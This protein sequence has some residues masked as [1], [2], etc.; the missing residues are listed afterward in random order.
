MFVVFSQCFVYM[1][2]GC[3]LPVGVSPEA[4]PTQG[5][6]VTPRIS[7]V[8]APIPVAILAKMGAVNIASWR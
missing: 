6:D 2:F 1:S 5:Y 8:F 7:V 3:F 4:G